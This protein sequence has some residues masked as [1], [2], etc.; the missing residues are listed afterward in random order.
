MYAICHT[1]K[2]EAIDPTQN[3]YNCP[4]TIRRRPDIGSILIMHDVCTSIIV[5]NIQYTYIYILY[6]ILN[7]NYL[8]FDDDVTQDQNYLNILLNI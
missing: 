5:I 8:A 3:V 2:D 1:K 7:P 4:Y 6:I